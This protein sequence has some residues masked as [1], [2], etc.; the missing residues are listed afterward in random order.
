MAMKK[1]GGTSPKKDNSKPATMKA[2]T[3]TAKKL[4]KQD[5]IS[6]GYGKGKQTFSKADIKTAVKSGTLKADTTHHRAM[7][8]SLGGN[9]DKAQSV[10]M[11]IKMAKNKKK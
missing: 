4:P 1:T 11:S 2:V 6:V 8:K 9:S 3:I 10:A 5:S 7:Q